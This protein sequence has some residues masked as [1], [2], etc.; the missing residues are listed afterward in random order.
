MFSFFDILLSKLFKLFNFKPEKIKKKWKM[1]WMSLKAIFRF[2]FMMKSEER[3]K[4]FMKIHTFYPRFLH[5][6]AL[7]IKVLVVYD[8]EIT[9]K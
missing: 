9:K 4:A 3:L 2:I 5:V 7:G 6:D 8:P 1:F